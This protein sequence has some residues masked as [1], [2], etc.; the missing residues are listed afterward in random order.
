MTHTIVTHS[1]GETERLGT[2]WGEEAGCGWIFGLKG[3]LGAGKTQLVKGIAKGLGVS[4]RVQSPTFVLVHEYP[5]GR[6][7]LYHLDLYRLD[8]EKAIRGAGLEQYFYQR[9]GVTVIEW[10]DRW[11]ELATATRFAAH[12]RYRFAVMEAVDEFG[13]RIAYEDFGA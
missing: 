6:L 11:P 13:R 3:E 7:P 2:R 5:G 1:P 4:A 9:N 12:T 8:D 10:V